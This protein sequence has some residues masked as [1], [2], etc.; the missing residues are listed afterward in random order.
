MFFPLFLFLHFPPLFLLDGTSLKMNI[1]EGRTHTVIHPR[2][3]DVEENNNEKLPLN[4][5]LGFPTATVFFTYFHTR[6]DTREA[7]G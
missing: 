2:K 6:E 5:S 7:D 3:D 1:T 4:D